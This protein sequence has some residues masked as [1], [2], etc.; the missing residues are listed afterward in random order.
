MSFRPS[1]VRSRPTL[2][3][4]NW[5]STGS[6][7]DEA[8]AG[9]IHCTTDITSL[10]TQSTAVQSTVTTLAAIPSRSSPTVPSG[11]KEAFAAANEV[12]SNGISAMENELDRNISTS[13][14]PTPATGTCFSNVRY[15]WD[16][17]DTY[18]SD[19]AYAAA[20]SRPD[21]QLPTT[22]SSDNT[23]NQ[24][25]ST[26]AQDFS[27]T[28]GHRHDGTPGSYGDALSPC[29]NGP[30]FLRSW[31]A[32]T[33]GLNSDIL[34]WPAGTQ[35]GRDP[36]S[37]TDF[38]E[39]EDVKALGLPLDLAIGIADDHF[40]IVDN[41]TNPCWMQRD[42]CDFSANVNGYTAPSTGGPD[43]TNIL[44]QL[45]SWEKLSDLTPTGWHAFYNK[46]RRFSFKWKI[47]LMPFG[48]INLKYQCLGHGL[49]TCGVGLPHYKRMGDALFLILEYLLP[50]S[51]PI[52][53]TTLDTLATSPT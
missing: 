38:M 4:D 36:V 28:S 35:T 42:V 1:V 33:R 13:H 2:I 15:R 20:Q 34:A 48:A 47:S 41:W 39:A 5:T 6:I 17:T 7:A 21:T 50:M 52:V 49:C 45:S 8:R 29:Y 23:S 19:A 16:P 43:I 9:V 11:I 40:D 26:R 27:S 12:I 22:P 14:T 37:G 51:H 18:D 46:L 30:S 10:S 53:A 44:K 3:I 32:L 25:Y 24:D 31:T